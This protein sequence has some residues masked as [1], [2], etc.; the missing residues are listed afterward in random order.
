MISV[1]CVGSVGAEH[2]TEAFLE[3]LVFA[4]KSSVDLKAV[5]KRPDFYCPLE[6]KQYLTFPGSAHCAFCNHFVPTTAIT[7]H[8]HS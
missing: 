4:Q 2:A 5:T 8:P 7:T 3:D 6:L 1:W